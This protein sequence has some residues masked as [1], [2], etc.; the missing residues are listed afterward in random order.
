MKKLLIGATL[1]LVAISVLF[2]FGLPAFAQSYMA[3]LIPN[4]PLSSI[5]AKQIII[6]SGLS[7]EKTATGETNEVTRGRD[8]VNAYRYAHSMLYTKGWYRGISEDHTPL[9]LAMVNELENEG[10]TSTQIITQ[11]KTAEVLQKFWLASDT[12]NAQELGYDSLEKLQTAISDM[13]K[14]GNKTD[15]DLLRIAIDSKWK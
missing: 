4:Q 8:T 2:T 12:Q 1:G 6:N 9:I 10:F 11:D 13:Q 7:I 14:S 3:T 5:A 15:A